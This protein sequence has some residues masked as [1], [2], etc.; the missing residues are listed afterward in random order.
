MQIPRS[1]VFSLLCFVCFISSSCNGQLST[2]KSIK[3]SVDSLQKV[4][5]IDELLNLYAR[6]GKLNGSILVAHHG[7]IMYK[8]GFGF[9]NMEWKVPNEPTTKHKLASISKQ[10]TAMLI[11]QLYADDKLQLDTPI[12]T[13]LPEYPRQK[14]DYI[15]IHQLL[16][17]T[18]GIQ[19]YGAV[20]HYED[21]EREQFSPKE[22]VDLMA[23]TSLHAMPGYVYQYSNTGYMVL[24]LII[25][26]I[27]N[28]PYHEVLQE[29]IL[30]PLG[31]EN[32]GFERNLTI[33]PNKS[34]GYEYD[35]V[36]GQ[37]HKAPYINMSTV[38][39]AGAI[40]S[41]VEDLYLWDQAL[42]TEKL[43]PKE[44]MEEYL[45]GHI[46]MFRGMYGYG[47]Q[48][49]PLSLGVSGSQVDAIGHGGGIYGYRTRIIR[50]PQ[51]QSSIIILNNTTRVNA[52]EI[53]YAI[54]A[55]LYD[56]DYSLPQKSMADTLAKI[57]SEKDIETAY[58]FYENNQENGDYY[59]DENEM[60]LMGYSLLVSGKAESASM[61]F[62]WNIEKF[63][64]SFNVYDSYAEAL[65]MLGRKEESIEYYKK[66]LEMN[67]DNQNGVK[68]L[69][70]LMQE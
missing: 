14:A 17:H 70:K 56:K 18:S 69:K 10:F 36:F 19:D 48:V 59:T 42:Y 9:A 35:Y 20:M 1:G 8:K 34:S 41:T 68:M 3:E 60:N 22:L 43:L 27:C 51:S 25:E 49:E 61:V 47:W 65:M 33:I 39:A 11:M 29:R 64:H 6:Y 15:T 2:D 58:S 66:S 7:Q 62:K 32:T 12:S 28:K 54:G 13:Y 52:M 5:Q 53:V 21:F 55:I 63:P 67:P 26:T 30:D 40:Y 16:T 50:I 4:T 38:Y 31:M 24:G 57:I 45:K 46:T 44:M 23:D 37:F